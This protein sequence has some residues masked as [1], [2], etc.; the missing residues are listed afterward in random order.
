MSVL[1]GEGRVKEIL[2][3]PSQ[4]QEVGRLQVAKELN[5]TEE[6]GV[7]VEEGG[8][9]GRRPEGVHEMLLHLPII[10]SISEVLRQE[11]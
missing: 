1:H 3:R 10:M 5:A 4:A 6:W 11:L 2:G 8:Y 9:R 7:P